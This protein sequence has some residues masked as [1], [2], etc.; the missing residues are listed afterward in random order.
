MDKAEAAA[1]AA[2]A[3][4]AEAGPEPSMHIWGATAADMVQ[5]GYFQLLQEAIKGWAREGAATAAA[6]GKQKKTA[7]AARTPGVSKWG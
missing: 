2:A 1:A 6:G 4:F 7:A 5:P 3:A